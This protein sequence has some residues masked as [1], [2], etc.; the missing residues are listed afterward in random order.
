MAQLIEALRRKVAGSI[1]NG[2][3]GI[4]HWHNPSG[5][6]DRG[7]DWAS[8]RNECQEY[9]LGGKVSR[10]IGLTTLPPSCADCYEIWEPKHPGTLSACLGLYRDRFT[11]AFTSRNIV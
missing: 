4:I 3:T 2:I 6:Y 8:N 11:F 5:G 10:C 1:P 7:V 9:F